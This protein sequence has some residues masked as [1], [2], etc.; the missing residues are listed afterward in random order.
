MVAVLNEMRTHAQSCVFFANENHEPS[1]DDIKITAEDWK[2]YKLKFISVNNFPTAAGLASSASGGAALAFALAN[3]FHTDSIPEPFPGWLSTIA[4]QESGSACR[5]IYG[6][7]VEWVEGKHADGSD[8]V[9]VERFPHD[10]W[11]A[12]RCV[13]LVVHAG[14]KKTGSTAGMQ[15]TIDSSALFPQRLKVVPG[16]IASMNAAIRNRDFPAFA[17][18]TMQDSHNFHA[19]C[20]DTF[21][22]IIYMTDTSHHIVEL[23]HA[24]N[25]ARGEVVAC[26][27]FDAGPNAVLYTL[28]PHFGDLL[29]LMTEQFP[30]ASLDDVM[31]LRAQAN[32]CRD[33]LDAAAAQTASRIC[34]RQHA[35]TVTRMIVTKVGDGPRLLQRGVKRN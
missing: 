20:M 29:N 13:I 27:T 22:P 25:K 32:L 9:A 8:S 34:P 10:H 15:E 2:N 12:M 6:G 4:R 21:P 5:S 11:P 14:E 17:N 1:S 19:C 23:V 18:L 28:E 24:F 3:L 30:S 7:F 26:Y 16:R 33:P 31:S 35:A